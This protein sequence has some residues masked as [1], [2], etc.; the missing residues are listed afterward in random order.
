MED[1]RF[2]MLA[3]GFEEDYP[4]L[5]SADG[6]IFPVTAIGTVFCNIRMAL[7]QLSACITSNRQRVSPPSPCL[8]QGNRTTRQE[9]ILG[10][11]SFGSDSFSRGHAHSQFSRA[12]E[13]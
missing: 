11:R 6:M 10:Y 4:N 12:T 9:E 5:D 2:Q 13:L 3:L 8:Y 1:R 7:N